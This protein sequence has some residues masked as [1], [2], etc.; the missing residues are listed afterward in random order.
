MMYAPHTLYVKR[1]REMLPDAL[2]RL[3]AAPGAAGGE[4][5]PVGQ[6]R[7]DDSG[8]REVVSV[9]GEVFRPSFRIVL[10]KGADVRAGDTVRAVGADGS[11]RGEGVVSNV[12]STNYLGYMTVYV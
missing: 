6:C 2:G 3:V 10:D 5:A 8:I 7:C 11:T 12:T 4:W 9:N 1:R